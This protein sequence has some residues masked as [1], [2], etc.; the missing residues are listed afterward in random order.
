MF[1]GSFSYFIFNLFLSIFNFFH[2]LLFNL[3]LSFSNFCDRGCLLKTLVP[4]LGSCISN[5]DH[6]VFTFSFCLVCYYA[7]FFIFLFSHLFILFFSFFSQDPVRFHYYVENFLFLFPLFLSTL[8]LLLYSILLILDAIFNLHSLSPELISLALEG[9]IDSHPGFALLKDSGNGSSSPSHGGGIPPFSEDC[10]PSEVSGT[11]YAE[12]L[13]VFDKLESAPIEI[14][15]SSIDSSVFTSRDD[16]AIFE[17]EPFAS[18]S[19]HRTFIPNHSPSPLVESVMPSSEVLDVEVAGTPDGSYSGRTNVEL[20]YYLSPLIGGIF[21]SSTLSVPLVLRLLQVSPLPAPLPPR[22]LPSLSILD[23]VHSPYSSFYPRVFPTDLFVYHFAVQQALAMAPPANLTV[24]PRPVIHSPYLN[25]YRSVLFYTNDF[26]VPLSA[27][28]YPV[29]YPLALIPSNVLNNN[30]LITS[31]FFTDHNY[32][33]SGRNPH[34]H[35]FYTDP[36]FYDHN[37]FISSLTP[38]VLYYP[39]GPGGPF[40]ST[41]GRIPIGFPLSPSPVIHSNGFCVYFSQEDAYSYGY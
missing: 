28:P 35:R 26:P 12:L 38:T 9:P 25:Y 29:G 31:I 16:P 5:Y 13:D 40:L 24:H 18:S 36:I 27:P 41:T 22:V 34:P 30:L 7:W 8:Y 6:F 37:Y 21:R 10:S 15:E 14:S 4:F 2:P 32:V 23:A 11:L 19:D 1:F 17:N 33:V 3:L 20:S 39:T